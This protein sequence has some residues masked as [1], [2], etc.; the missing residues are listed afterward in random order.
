MCVC[1]CVYIYI[2]IYTY[3]HI[4]IYICIR[5]GEGLE[6]SKSG[7]SSTTR[8]FAETLKPARNSGKVS[9][10]APTPYEY[11]VASTFQKM[12]RG[13]HRECTATQQT[14][15]VPQTPHHPPTP[16]PPPPP[17]CPKPS[18]P[19]PPSPASTTPLW[20]NAEALVA[21][22]S[23]PVCAQVSKETHYCNER[24][25]LEV[26]PGPSC[27]TAQRFRRGVGTPA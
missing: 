25:P 14:H 23:S 15:L 19:S 12:C 24:N 7:L 11:T 17:P 13:G 16:P 6:G 22:N 27:S 2:C 21:L 10:Q 5:P 4:Y 26:L 8:K 1:V 3:I 20:L 9:A 18:P